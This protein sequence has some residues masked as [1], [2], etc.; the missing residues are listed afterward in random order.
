M[1]TFEQD[2]NHPK[3]WDKLDGFVYSDSVARLLDCGALR[4]ATKYIF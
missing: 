1:Y 3:F 2:I 4:I